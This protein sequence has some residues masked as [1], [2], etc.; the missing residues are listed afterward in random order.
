ML[1]AV[2]FIC[3]FGSLWQFRLK[4]DDKDKVDNRAK[5][6]QDELDRLVNE[7]NAV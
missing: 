7:L 5:Q 2:R 6:L 3:P 4:N 1:R